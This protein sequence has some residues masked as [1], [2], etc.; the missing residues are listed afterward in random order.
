MAA[1]RPILDRLM[2]K[3]SPEPN[4]GCWLWTSVVNNF[5][6]GTMST[7]S[8]SDG[9]W[10]PRI[11]SRLVYETLVGPI[12]GG[13]CACHKCD[14]PAC[15]NPD[16]LFLGTRREN[17]SDMT[18]KGR[19]TRGERASISKLTESAVRRLREQ[20]AQG[21]RVCDLARELRINESTARDAITGRN[22]RHLA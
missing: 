13:L 11:A 7:R 18:R 19:S 22:W 14:T 5:G 1:P 4:T 6:Y 3:I 15:V 12:P 17:Q 16:H 10:R 8:E 2:E 20:H 9:R 21:R